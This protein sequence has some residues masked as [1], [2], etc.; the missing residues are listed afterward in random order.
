MKVRINI[1]LAFVVTLVI[2]TTLL[3]TGDNARFAPQIG[4][5]WERPTLIAPFDFAIEK[6]KEEMEAEIAYIDRTFIPIY[7]YDTLLTSMGVGNFISNN[8]IAEDS[9]LRHIVQGVRDI[10]SIGILPP[11]D[12]ATTL[13]DSLSHLELIRLVRDGEITTLSC[14]N[15]YTPEQAVE[16]LKELAGDNFTIDEDA[17]SHIT[18]NLI[19]D[20]DLNQQVYNQLVEN[21]SAY[22]E[23]ISRGAT[24]VHEGQIIDYPT[25]EILSSYISEL[26]YRE[27]DGIN[28]ANLLGNL[29]FVAIILILTYIFIFRFRQGVADRDSNI[30]F[31]LFIY[32]AMVFM[33]YFVSKSSFL[34]I[35]MIPFG[36]VPLYI[37]TFY[38]IRMSIFEYTL[39]LILCS[40]MAPLPFEFFA[41]NLTAGVSGVFVL[42]KSY[43]RR[44]IFDAMG[45]M[46]AVYILSFYSLSF[47]QHTTDSA[48][49][50]TVP[51]WFA[52]NIMLVMVLYQSL[53]LIEKSFGFVTNITLLELCDTNTKLLRELAEKAPGT[54][55]HSLHVASLAEE[56]ASKI[57]ANPLLARTG[58]LYHDIGKSLNPLF[59]IENVAND[60]NPHLKLT[61]KESAQIIK[62]HVT[63]GVEL[64]RKGNLPQVIVDFI[65]S[66]HGTSLISYFH[67]AYS[68]ESG[69]GDDPEIV[70]LFSYSGAKPRSKEATICSMADSVEAASRSLKDKSIEGITALVDK[71]IDKQ[72]SD[73][74]FSESTLSFAE[75]E[76][77]KE[78]FKLKLAG[79]YHTRIVYPE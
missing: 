4:T 19:Y 67:Y 14:T 75:L 55:Q 56:A 9:T 10:Y 20:R 79:I 73:N 50:W 47:I 70:D 29:I 59:F 8:N 69:D 34:N 60:Q 76:T 62:Q 2:I 53:Y 21:I 71:L 24:L 54:F 77:V 5:S 65:I 41:V 64:A 40:V 33:M 11:Q 72:I 45:T 49:T 28:A 51:M 36:I 63:D 13:K 46:F 3:P 57:G 22:K 44:R 7:R 15:L 68:Q 66:H 23:F 38:D 39:V 18:S 25:Y 35:Y 43:R 30:F 52:I 1:I 32:V 31:L 37:V 61:P 74:D 17:A 48:F 16:H 58:A 12:M 78:T 27:R 42:Q 26:K 6:S